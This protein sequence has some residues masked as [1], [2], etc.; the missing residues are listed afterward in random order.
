MGKKL[1]AGV[2]RAIRSDHKRLTG[3][4]LKEGAHITLAKKY[5]LSVNYVGLI[6]RRRTWAWVTDERDQFSDFLIP[7]TAVSSLNPHDKMCPSRI[8]RRK[9]KLLAGLKK[10]TDV[11][12]P[13]KIAE[14]VADAGRKL[15]H[16]VVRYIRKLSRE[17]Y[18]TYVIAKHLGLNYERVISIVNGDNFRNVV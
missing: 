7:D 2:I 11:P 12:P 4:G 5:A 3:L 18:P 8:C 10:L 6:V 17:N 13:A 9:A 14:L 16:P 1:N 15:S